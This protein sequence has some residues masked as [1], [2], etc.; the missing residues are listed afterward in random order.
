MAPRHKSPTDPR[1]VAKA[2][3]NFV[4][5]PDDVVRAVES[6]EQLPDHNTYGNDSYP[7]TGYINVKLTTKTPL[8]IRTGF[9]AER[10]PGQTRTEY[11]QAEYERRNPPQDFRRAL[12]NKPDFFHH[13]DPTKPVIPGSS[14]RGMLRQL[15]EI[16]T[17]SKVND[18]P[19]RQLVY[20]AVGDRS[21][22]GDHYREQMLGSN[23]LRFPDMRYDYSSVHVKGGYLEDTGNGWAIRPAVSQMGE[24]IIRVP[25]HVARPVIGGQGRLLVHDLYVAPAARAPNRRGNRGNGELTLDMAETT[26]VSATPASGLVPAKLVES[27]HMGGGH[28]K[29]WH[30][31]I[32]EPD[33]MS[34]LLPIPDEMWGIYSDDRDMTRDPRRG[35]L[36]IK[37]HGDPLF[38]L[39]DPASGKLIY[40]G[41][42]AMFRLVYEH[43]PLD[44]V[45]QAL[46]RPEV[47]DLAE[48][49]FGYVRNDKE[50]ENLKRRQLPEPK[51]GEKGRAYAG[52]V[53]VSDAKLDAGQHD[54]WLPVNTP[55]GILEPSILA[56]PKP[57]TFQHYLTQASPDDWKALNHYDSND[58]TL[59]GHKLYWAKGE[60]NAESL[61]SK[62]PSEDPDNVPGQMANQFEEVTVNGNRRWRV[63]SGNSQHTRMRPV[64]SDKTF[65]FQIY[66]ENLSAVELGALLWALH[67]PGEQ[68][69]YVHR[70][71]MGKPLGMGCVQLDPTLHLVV[72]RERYNKLLALEE[73]SN[74]SATL[75][76]WFSGED[77]ITTEQNLMDAFEEFILSRLPANLRATKMAGVER[78]QMLLKMLEWNATDADADKKRY[79]AD[80][81]VFRQRRVLPDPLEVPSME[82]DF[83]QEPRGRQGQSGRQQNQQP[84]WRQQNQPWNRQSTRQPGPKP[85]KPASEESAETRERRSS[86]ADDIMNRLRNQSQG[87]DEDE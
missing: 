50:L 20:R 17:Y 44:L 4:P 80:L 38:Y 63:K 75:G 43:S 69:E 70:L 76:A 52:R 45:P 28:A 25:Y 85:E 55:D 83:T 39:V 59:R 26:L 77:T 14:L 86:L 11:E 68:V 57:T 18:V 47:V 65:S 22:L 13:G 24:S 33:T 42:T 81:Q 60:V 72:A 32:Y 16:I 9:S 3:Y 51:Q 73:T 27:G 23:K 79:M 7:Y 10:R 12:R 78:I 48:A 8:Y 19:D 34:S 30:C 66:F 87:E 31:A 29:H 62:H 54:I 84:R 2:P 64:N 71:G 56:S 21:A 61:R 1:R 41:S 49:M 46:R 74:G 82:P 58:T 53:Y 36:E 15:V 35:T 5:L 67:L 6:P 37:N 40:F